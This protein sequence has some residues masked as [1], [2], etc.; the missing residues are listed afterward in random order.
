MSVD[1]QSPE[2]EIGEGAW[3]DLNNDY[4]DA[5]EKK[6]NINDELADL[7]VEKLLNNKK[8]NRMLQSYDKIGT[9]KR[10]ASKQ[11]VPN[12][13]SSPKTFKDIVPNVRD[14]VPLSIGNKH[15]YLQDYLDGLAIV[16][17][18]L[19]EDFFDSGFPIKLKEKVLR[20]KLNKILQQRNI[21]LLNRIEKFM[22]VLVLK[23]LPAFIEESLEKQE[24]EKKL[25]S[26]GREFLYLVSKFD[27]ISKFDHEYLTTAVKIFVDFLNDR[28][29]PSNRLNQ[30]SLRRDLS[31][32][33]IE[34]LNRHLFELRDSWEK[35]L[36]S[37]NYDKGWYS[38]IGIQYRDFNEFKAKL[39][40]L[41]VRADKDRIR[42]SQYKADDTAIY[43]FQ[44]EMYCNKKSVNYDFFGKF[45]TSLI[46]I[47][48][49]SSLLD[50]LVDYINI[51][52]E[53]GE[54]TLQAD[55]VLFFDANKLA[56][57]NGREN[58]FADVRDN[59]KKI[60]ENLL[61]KEKHKVDDVIGDEWEIQINQIPVLMNV[62]S[63]SI[64]LLES[65]SS[66][67][68]VVY[69]KLIP[70]FYLMDS[71]EREYSD[72]IKSRISSGRSTKDAKE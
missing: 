36:Y 1:S 2:S 30:I 59:L 41:A 32:P 14:L 45:F 44:I 43:R 34:N 47:A 26:I 48:K 18:E 5:Q 62:S 58:R 57:S 55:V 35:G 15:S 4:L 21:E 63:D 22:L 72:S 6:E 13:H 37:F 24:Y 27:Q 70:Y 31:L 49:K 17:S 19:L 29:N 66:L 23:P 33:S 52:K 3:E 7:I 39:K 11:G 10:Y 54:S 68:K 67:W 50:G 64:W 25:T 61:E 8:L 42:F 60:A 12:R 71:F 16:N 46:K 9:S 69:T 65:N 53:M 56:V 40:S 51:W 38:H 28:C 20:N